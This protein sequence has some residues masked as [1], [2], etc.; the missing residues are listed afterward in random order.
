MWQSE[1]VSNADER[2]K[3]MIVLKQQNLEKLTQITNEVSDPT[4]E[5]YTNVSSKKTKQKPT[6]YSL[7]T[8]RL[9]YFVFLSIS[10]L[11]T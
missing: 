8:L 5:S 9:T 4:H 7:K 6:L 3:F 11:Q 10:N 1:G 2:V